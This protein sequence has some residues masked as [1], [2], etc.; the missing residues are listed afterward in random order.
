MLSKGVAK[1]TEDRIRIIVV[2]DSALFRLLIRDALKD[3]TAASVIG[4]AVSGGHALKLVRER[5]PDLITLDVE[6][7]DLN[8]IE[9]LR[10]L[11]RRGDSTRAIM[12]SRLTERGAEVTT[13]A[14]LEGAFDFILK[15]SSDNPLRNKETLARELSQKIN[16]FRLSRTLTEERPLELYSEVKMPSQGSFE[17]LLIGAS[18]GGPDALREL[19][20]RLPASFSLPV[21]VVQHMPTQYTTRLAARLNEICPLA[22]QEAVDRTIIRPGIIFIAPCGKRMKVSRHEGQMQIRLTEDPPENSCRPAVDYLL[23][24][25]AEVWK[26]RSMTVILTGMGQDGTAGCRLIKERGGYIIAQRADG[27]VVYG[28]PKSV[29]DNSLADCTLALPRIAAAVLQLV[30]WGRRSS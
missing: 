13:D 7:P 21:L 19:L 11:R 1:L 24:S 18:T 20:P 26:D 4:N 12:L 2:D 3:I 25:A 8:G 28:M 15:P 27:C 5:Q 22:V 30:S 10:E 17:A 14:L 29:I 6:M 9:V 23:R 16:A